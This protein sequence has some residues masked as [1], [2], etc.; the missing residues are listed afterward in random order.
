LHMCFF[1]FVGG[2]GDEE[3]SARSSS[4]RGRYMGADKSLT[5]PG[6]KQPNISVRMA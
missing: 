6:K 2:W 4:V 3:L 1:F 5:R